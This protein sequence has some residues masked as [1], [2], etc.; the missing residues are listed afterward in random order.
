LLAYVLI[1]V[2]LPLGIAGVFLVSVEAMRVEN[3]VR[4][5]NR[6]IV[7]YN[8]AFPGLDNPDE[9]GYVLVPIRTLLAVLEHFFISGL[10]GLLAALAAYAVFVAM[11]VPRLLGFAWLQLLVLVPG[12]FGV[13]L[14]G[15]ASGIAGYFLMRLAGAYALLSLRTGVVLLFRKTPSG[16]VAVI[17][18]VLIVLSFILQFSGNLML[19]I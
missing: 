6:A 17:G 10:I 5:L 1:L 13:A 16:S 3:F 18:F 9:N 2:A 11:L 4:L 12:G 15:F 19:I 8:R 7:L 14:I